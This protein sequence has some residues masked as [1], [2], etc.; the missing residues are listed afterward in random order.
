MSTTSP[1]ARSKSDER[2]QVGFPPDFDALRLADRFSRMVD[3]EAD[4][5]IVNTVR[6]HLAS[7]GKSNTFGLEA[8]C[9]KIVGSAETLQKAIGDAA[10]AIERNF[11]DGA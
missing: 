7:K 10:M 9:A 8:E 3:N 1:R 2:R 11:G 4:R 6:S 5:A